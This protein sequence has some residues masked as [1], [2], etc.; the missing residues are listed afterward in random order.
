MKEKSLRKILLYLVSMSAGALL[1]DVFI[2]L[3]PD[4]VEETGFSLSVSFS[5]L[6]GILFFFIVEKFLHW[7]HCHSP[8]NKHTIHPIAVTNLVGDM[9]HNFLDGIIIGTSYL[10]SI[11]AGIAT[12]IAVALH[13]I[14]QEIGDFAILLHAG[15]SKNKA[16][17]YNF[18]TALF[19]L[20]GLAITFVASSYIEGL[21]RFLVPFAA[22]GFIYIAGSD[23][24]PE[25]HKES[26][27]KKSILQLLSLGFWHVFDVFT[28]V[29]GMTTS[30]SGYG[31]NQD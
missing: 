21:T 18:I 7:H 30:D 27:T 8:H 22:G 17:L 6:F 24:I 25:I 5:I 29:F 26:D 15:L 13:E 14:P 4:I 31:N 23:L 3:L 20:L 10:V 11:P 19:A 16:I 28:G 9:F 1:A 2:H 12:T